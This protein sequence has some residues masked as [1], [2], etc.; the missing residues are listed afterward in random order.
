M[1]PHVWLLFT[2]IALVAWGTAGLLQKVSTNYISA[3]SA[4]VWLIA[5]F[6]VVEPWLWK[7]GESSYLARDAVIAALS[8]GL[9]ALAFWALLEAMESG[10][11]AAIVV[12]LTSMYPLLV[13]LIA[14]LVLHERFTL[15][16][17]AGIA[18]GL[19]AIY[20]FAT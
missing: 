18:C 8:G 10:G 14:P 11:K 3:Q 13:V 2:A 16:Q 17:G 1:H 15:Q 9:S 4:L 6:V 19:G 20:L 5:G 12:P 7:P